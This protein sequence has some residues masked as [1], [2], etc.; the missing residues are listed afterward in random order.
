MSFMPWVAAC[1]A[2]GIKGKVVTT[3]TENGHTTVHEHDF[4]NWTEFEDAMGEVATDFSAFA[5]EVGSVTSRLVKQLVDVPP[6]GHVQLGDLDPRLEPFQGDVR[7]D[8]LKVATMQPNPAYDFT[9]VRLGMPDYD[10]FFK[11]SAQMYAT[12]YQLMETG[13]HIVLARAAA[14]GEQ[15]DSEV[16]AGKKKVPKRQVE[17]ALAQLRSSSQSDVADKAQVL[18]TLYTSVVTL[19]A[20]LAS[21]S[22]DTISTGAQLVASAPKQI[23]NPKLV[24]HLGL[25]VEGLSK[26]VALVRDTAGLLGQIT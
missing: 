21:K 17:D 4:K 15:P 14:V 10:A 1:E 22:A 25:I 13:R 12:A 8:Y 19:G 6:P 2:L 23:L 26:S 20:E 16:D 3:V 24:L 11:A 18:G 5:K 7:Y 9:Y